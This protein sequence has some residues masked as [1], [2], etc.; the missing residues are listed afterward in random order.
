MNR[1]VLERGKF[2]MGGLTR[3]PDPASIRGQ[4]DAC[5]PYNPAA[6][7]PLNATL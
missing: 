5:P 4:W 7:E 6:E 1:T 3:G 2:R